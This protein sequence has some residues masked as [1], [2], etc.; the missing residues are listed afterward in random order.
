MEIKVKTWTLDLKKMLCMAI[1]VGDLEWVSVFRIL[2]HKGMWF[3]CQGW[4]GRRKHTCF[5]WVVY[6]EFE[7]QSRFTFE[8]CVKRDRFCV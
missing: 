2:S 8:Y 4:N 1:F 6:V 5:S 3:V 7:N